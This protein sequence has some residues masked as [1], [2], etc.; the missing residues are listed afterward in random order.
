[1]KKRTLEARITAAEESHLKGRVP[2]CLR[3]LLNAN[4]AGGYRVEV[5]RFDSFGRWSA[6]GDYKSKHFIGREVEDFKSLRQAADYMD[7]FYK[8]YDRAYGVPCTAQVL[9]LSFRPNNKQ[10]EILQGMDKHLLL[11]GDEREIKP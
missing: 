8:T 11:I 3:Y 6:V 5:S 2:H 7:K 9:G 1:M 4:P 10:I